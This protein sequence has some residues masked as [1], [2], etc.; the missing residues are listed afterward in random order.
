MEKQ[1]DSISWINQHL[2]SRLEREEL[3]SIRDFSLMWNL[4]ENV[5]CGRRFDYIR[6]KILIADSHL[7]ADDFKNFIQYFRDR[8]VQDDGSMDSRF[9]HLRISSNNSPLVEAVLT[10]ANSDNDDIILAGVVIIYR[11]R[12]NLFHGEKAIRE[13]HTQTDNFNTANQFIA[14]FLDRIRPG[15]RSIAN[16]SRLDLFSV[17]DPENAS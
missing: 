13:L 15:N 4:F 3:T 9:F 1:F 16:Q 8:Y 17:N 6:I 2:N 5:A 14:T 7:R 10:G 11:L 12:N